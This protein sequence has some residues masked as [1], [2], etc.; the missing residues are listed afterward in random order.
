MA[1]FT[2]ITA[3]PRAH[4]LSDLNKIG[5]SASRA[6]SDHCRSSWRLALWSRSSLVRPKNCPR[7]LTN[8]SQDTCI[9]L[10]YC[11]RA[12]ECEDCS[13]VAMRRC[14]YSR[15]RTCCC[16]CGPAAL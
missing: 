9:W 14:P 7:S 1:W 11:T 6:P 15:L 10:A 13:N 5:L 16:C 2:G 3:R 8:R 4:N 12:S